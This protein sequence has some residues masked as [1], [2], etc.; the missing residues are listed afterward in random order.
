MSKLAGVQTRNAYEVAI[1]YEKKIDIAAEC[2]RLSKELTKLE[3][4]RDRA[5]SQLSNESFLAKAPANVVAGLRRRCAELEQLI[6]KA[7]SGLDELK[8]GGASP[9]GSHG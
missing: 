9:N 4:E 5:R 1:P 6:L 7:R 2:A 8:K 3:S